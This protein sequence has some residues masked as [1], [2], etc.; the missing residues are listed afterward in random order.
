MSDNQEAT[1]LSLSVD[2]NQQVAIARNSRVSELDWFRVQTVFG[3]SE[4]TLEG[5]ERILCGPLLFESKAPWLKSWERD[6]N[7]VSWSE[8]VTLLLLE[9]R[10][11]SK[12]F[13][14]LLLADP[15]RHKDKQVKVP[16]LLRKLKKEQHENILCLLDA[17]NG[18]NFS[19]PGAGKTLTTLC[20]WKILKSQGKV[21]RL[22]VICPRSAFDSWKKE[23]LESF[24]SDHPIE[25]LSGDPVHPGVQIG[26]V[27]YEKLENP[28]KLKNIMA[29]ATAEHSQLVVDEAHRIKGG[30][31][32]VRWEACRR[33]SQAVTRVDILTGTPM[34]NSPDDLTALF[35]L[36]WPRL[37][38]GFLK[39]RDFSRLRRKTVFVRTTKD[40]LNLPK[41]EIETIVGAASP[42]HLQILEALRDTY[43]GTFALS[44]AEGQN[45]TSRGKAVMTMLAATTNPGLLVSKKFSAIEFGFTWPPSEISENAQLTGL[46]NNYLT[47]DTPWKYL[48]VID[49]VGR[50]AAEG[51]KVV[52]W[53]SFVGNLAAMKRYLKKFDPAVVYG[54]T[55]ATDRATEIE[56]FKNSDNCSVL[57]TNPQTLGEGISLHM[58]CN[59]AIYIDRTF[60]AGHYLQSVDRIHR[61][62]LPPGRKTKIHFLQTENSIDQ[63]VA[64]RLAQ[65]IRALSKF[66]Q[67]TSLT[68]TAIPTAE[69]VPAEEA[70]GLTEED[71]AEIVA[72]IERP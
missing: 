7:T 68:Q 3:R 49:I 17:P 28:E 5:C 53:S 65:K 52:V 67:D 30:E 66:L 12:I 50:R 57:L 71:F 41:V 70:L 24:S 4:I 45:L 19:V 6:K 29:W 61:L 38:E 56:K 43:R 42:L 16:N 8:D 36:T 44:I 72:L 51:K 26:L 59:D 46:I 32:S 63:R 40:E 69:E 23:V 22:L 31:K 35:G 33:L 60:N 21:N 54:G 37:Q 18:S 25:V 10:K 62:G 2:E 13:Q 15:H 9:I 64:T 11:N 34:P 27:N 48:Q 58:E 1:D 39:S 55:S 47:F 20:L 14:S